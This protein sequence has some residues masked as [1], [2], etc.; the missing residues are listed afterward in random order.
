[1]LQ[2]FV[3][4]AFAW[5]EII[6]GASLVAVPDLPCV[7]L[8]AAKA[9]GLGVLLARLAGLGLLALGIAYLPSTATISRRS[10]VGPFVYNVGATILLVWVG[11]GTTWHGFLLWP[12]AILHA[13]ITTALASQLL[14]TKD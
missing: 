4:V 2:R 8:F 3:V 1:M 11:V 10:V 9:E 5:I 13:A 7:L 12:A 14:T 6:F